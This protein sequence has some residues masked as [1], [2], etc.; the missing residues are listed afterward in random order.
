MRIACHR[1]VRMSVELIDTTKINSLLLYGCYEA[2][3]LA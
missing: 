2:L 3:S 1:H